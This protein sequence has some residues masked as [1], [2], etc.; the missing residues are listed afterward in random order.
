MDQHRS[1]PTVL[2]L[3]GVVVTGVLYPMLAPR[4]GDPLAVF[5]L[6][7]LGTAVVADHRVTRLV[8]SAAVVVAGIEGLVTDLTG[9]ALVARMLLIAGGVAMATWGAARRTRREL[10]LLDARVHETLSATFQQGLVPAPAPPPCIRAATR[11]RPAE[12]PLMLGGDFVDVITLPDASA[13][14]II[15][16][17]CGHGPTA[18]AFGTRIRAGWKS[19]AWTL[20]S[21]PERWLEALDRAFFLDGRFDGFVTAITGRMSCDGTVVAACA[22]H[23]RPLMIGQTRIDRVDVPSGLP[24]GIDPTICRVAAELHV[25]TGSSILLY[26]DG[27]IENRG[28]PGGRSSEEALM[29]ALPAPISSADLDRLMERFGPTGFDD[30]V[31]MLLLGPE[32]APVPLLSGRAVP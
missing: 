26:T 15:G 9:W 18:A 12:A 6:A 3:L 1:R 19:L 27:L 2:G 17:V 20:P 31:A 5:L 21:H 24:L 4:A 7:P 14:F 8:G 10:Q 29:R 30:D 25:P 13:G 11:Y 23:P 28:T 16:D 22:G 32:P